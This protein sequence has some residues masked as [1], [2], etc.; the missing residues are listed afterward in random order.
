[1]AHHEV[2]VKDGVR[3]AGVIVSVHPSI[4]SGGFG[5]IRADDGKDY[6][7]SGRNIFRNFSHA[8]VGGRVTFE[9]VEWSY[10]TNIDRTDKHERK[11]A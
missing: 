4:G 6:V 5:E 11:G 3:L 2:G 10:A 8:E 7:Y 1:M 9:V